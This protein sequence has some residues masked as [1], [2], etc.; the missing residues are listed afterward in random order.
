[1][2]L[3][4]NFNNFLR[5]QA[6]ALA[7]TFIYGPG[8]GQILQL[9]STGIPVTDPYTVPLVSGAEPPDGGGEQ[10]LQPGAGVPPPGAFL[11]VPDCQVGTTFKS[12]V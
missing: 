9:L 3:S 11:R 2:I 10:L 4:A 6:F 5:R 12:F 7:F 1:M 8:L